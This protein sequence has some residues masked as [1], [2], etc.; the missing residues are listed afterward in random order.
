MNAT[1]LAS[2][3]ATGGRDGAKTALEAFWKR[4]SR[5]AISSPLQPSWLDRV[6]ASHSLRFSPAF[7]MFDLMTR[8]FSPYE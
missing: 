7:V 1:V 2:G 4:V 8:L 3:L 5:A 6:F